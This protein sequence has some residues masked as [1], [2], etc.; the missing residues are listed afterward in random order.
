VIAIFGAGAIGCWVGGRLAAGGADVLL[1]GR[2]R[3]MDELS[4]GLH[5]SELGG[6]EA[7]VTPKVTID[8]K[9]AASAKI[10]LVTVKSA[11][12][13]EAGATL[14]AVLPPDAVVVSLQNG[15]RNADV[16][17]AALS[18]RRT[19]AAMVPFNVVRRGP[20]SY[21]RASGGA[22]RI[23][24]DP[25]AT[26][27]L[28]ACRA[29]GLPIEPRRDMLA[30]QWAKLVMNLNNAINALSGQPLAAELADRG[31]RRCLAAAQREALGLLALAKQ[32]VAKLTAI[33]PRWMPRLLEV[34]D[35]VFKLLAAR[36]VAIDPH[37]RSS[38]WDDFEAKRPT[39]IDY[40]QGEV[41][42]LAERLGQPA[43]INRTL[44]RLVREAEAGGKRDFTAGELRAAL[45]L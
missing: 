4:G 1:V 43:P 8:P 12:T 40:L 34:P 36:V 22:L 17:R 7:R 13:A 14:A 30:V 3:V 29:G 37:A 6:R 41:V 39:E 32:D 25:A 15:V 35:R 9:D 27:L 19:L 20:G 10:V 38:M 31:F 26:P 16:L 2:A 45:G 33:P 42:T 28:D 5:V 23:D 18:D 44:V 21:H 11:Q 24:D